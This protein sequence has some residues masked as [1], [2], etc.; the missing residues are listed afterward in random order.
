MP[1]LGHKGAISAGVGH[2]CDGGCVCFVACRST[3]HFFPV[4]PQTMAY[5]V[6][7]ESSC[8]DKDVSYI[9]LVA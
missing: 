3:N 5:W 8:L 6:L 7:L 1:H 9:V 4:N 2:G